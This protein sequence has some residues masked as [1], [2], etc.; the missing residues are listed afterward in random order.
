MSRDE[1][2]ETVGMMIIPTFGAATLSSS[3][4]SSWTR[5]ILRTEDVEKT[6]RD[7][8]PV[9]LY[10]AVLGSGVN[11]AAELIESSSS[12]QYGFLLDVFLW[13]RD[14]FTEDELW[15]WLEELDDAKDLQP[16][17]RFLRQIDRDLL[18][19]II[20]RNVESVFFE[21]SSQVPPGEGF[22]TP[23][24]GFTWINI[25]PDDPTVFRLCGRLLALLFQTNAEMFYQ[26]LNEAKARTGIE[27]EEE[28]YAEKTRRLLD[29]GLPDLESCL[30]LNTPRAVKS[31]HIVNDADVSIELP[32]IE[33]LL[34]PLRSVM[35]SLD[36][37]QELSWIA[38]AGLIYYRTDFSDSESV[39]E[40]LSSVNGAINIGLQRACGVDTQRAKALVE[41]SGLKMFYRAGLHELNQIK[42]IVT[43]RMPPESKLVEDRELRILVHALTLGIP[44]YPIFTQIDY[45]GSDPQFMLRHRAFISLSEVLT[46]KKIVETRINN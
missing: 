33:P 37:Q 5:E 19:L 21:E 41:Q 31:G 25:I 45:E 20:A 1:Q 38:S 39:V 22:F 10:L 27:L 46:V 17:S 9:T 2:D 16:M 6:V 40:L 35:L 18:T 4:I 13:N 28:A 42:Q 36:L 24:H 30:E 7:L 29:F 23:D 34:E 43:Q 3:N 44:R 11:E 26:L 8:P 32:E 15:R 14:Q 12:E